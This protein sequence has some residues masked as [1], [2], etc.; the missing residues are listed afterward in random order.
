M[1]RSR[2]SSKRG[3]TSSTP[4]ST[5]EPSGGPT[6]PPT[7]SPSDDV[8]EKIRLAGEALKTLDDMMPEQRAFQL[9]S[10][11]LGAEMKP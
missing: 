4:R 2:P 9:I 11:A 5:T 3:S 10:W 7:T 8:A 6:T 1:T